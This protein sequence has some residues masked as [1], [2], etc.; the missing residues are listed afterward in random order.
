MARLAI[1][2][3]PLLTA[4]LLLLRYKC[5]KVDV[6]DSQIQAIT[7]ILDGDRTIGE[8]FARLRTAMSRE[9][10]EAPV[11]MGAVVRMA[12]NF[13]VSLSPGEDDCEWILD[14]FGTLLETVAGSSREWTER[15]LARR[16]VRPRGLSGQLAL[17][18][19]GET[20][21][22]LEEELR[23]VREESE[24]LRRRYEKALV[25]LRV[26]EEQEW[27]QERAEQY[28]EQLGEKVAV[29][30]EKKEQYKVLVTGLG[31]KVRAKNAKIEQLREQYKQYRAQLL[32][33]SGAKD[34]E[35]LMAREQELRDQV[36]NYEREKQELAKQIRRQDA[37]VKKEQLAAYQQ[38]KKW[39]DEQQQ[40]QN[41]I[42][43]L[44]MELREA[45]EALNAAE[46][47]NQEFDSVR[48]L[49][50]QKDVR[51]QELERTIAGLREQVRRESPTVQATEPAKRGK[52]TKS[53]MDAGQ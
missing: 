26:L 7:Q 48:E 41:Q 52:R 45:Q 11:D 12:W 17:G 28:V 47:Q 23:R 37:Q 19:T 50:Q 20:V 49:V 53:Q 14:N 36:E 30:R 10:Q 3:T 39:E 43:K 4:V 21:A 1:P 35:E 29:L 22:A 24:L 32:G 15:D 13:V 40:Q 42:Q 18:E 25:G 16:E 34:M 6:G 8:T 5:L 31:E 38:A 44:Q 27:N 51:I 2:S 9:Q 46:A 33:R